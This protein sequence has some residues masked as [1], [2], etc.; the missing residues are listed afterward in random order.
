[1][2]LTYPL[3]LVR[4]QLAWITDAPD[5]TASTSGRSSS[6][7]SSVRGGSR[8]P[9]ASPPP[10]PFLSRAQ[11]HDA[12][13]PQHTIR[14]MLRL[15]ASTE[16]VRGLY[17]GISPTLLGIMPYSGI[18]FYVYNVL[19]QLYFTAGPPPPPPAGGVAAGRSSSSSMAAP[20]DADTSSS[21]SSSSSSSSSEAVIASGA[22]LSTTKAAVS[23]GSG[24]SGAAAPHALSAAPTTQ[25][26]QQ[27][28]RLPVGV[29]LLF[30]GVAGLAAQTITY[31]LDV[32]RRRMQ[33]RI[34]GARR[35]YPAGREQEDRL[36]LLLLRLCLPV[37]S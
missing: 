13:P 29:M 9:Q 23:V 14:S 15:T 19:K 36:F 16:G 30:G 27:Q 7:S 3:D 28:Q 12:P 5:A 22:T 26:Q 8:R 35:M 31:P 32:V 2:L 1:M 4:T 33:V 17:K 10:Q 20:P 6:G 25:A 37:T 24:S 11:R 34:G 18:K 21:A